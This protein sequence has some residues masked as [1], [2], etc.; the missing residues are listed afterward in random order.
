M[1]N[2]N[3]FLIVLEAGR[4][5]IKVPGDSVSGKSSHPHSQMMTC[6]SVLKGHEK[7]GD[8]LEPLL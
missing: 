2:R 4:F 6:H 3:S 1:D 5:K 8:S 7:K